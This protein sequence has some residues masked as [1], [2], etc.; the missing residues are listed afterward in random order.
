[1]GNSTS[2]LVSHRNAASNSE[3]LVSE[4]RTTLAPQTSASTNSA[5]LADDFVDGVSTSSDSGESSVELPNSNISSQSRGDAAGNG[6]RVQVAALYVESGGAYYDLPGVDPWDARRD[7]RTYAGP[8]CG[9]RVRSGESRRRVGKAV[10]SRSPVEFRD[11]LLSMAR[12]ASPRV[13]S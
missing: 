7:A 6:I 8:W 12:T 11:A 5:I 10:A 4:N 1:M 9:N 2:R 13:A 3:G